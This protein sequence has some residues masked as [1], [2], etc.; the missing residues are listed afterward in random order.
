MCICGAI[1]MCYTIAKNACEG[2]WPRHYIGPSIVEEYFLD[3]CIHTQTPQL[4]YTTIS[5][6][7][8]ICGTV[9]YVLHCYQECMFRNH[10]YQSIDVKE[11]FLSF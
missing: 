1:C 9:L 7:V 11:I 6:I 4:V 5:D 8:C 10:Y 2:G 3:V